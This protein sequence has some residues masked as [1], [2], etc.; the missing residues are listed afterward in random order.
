M[1]TRQRDSTTL[2]IAKP[3]VKEPYRGMLVI[4]INSNSA[5]AAEIFARVMQIEQRGYVVGDRSMGA[6]ITSRTYWREVGGF[7]R[8]LSYGSS[9]S[10]ADV[11]MSDGGRIENV[12]VMPNARVLLTG[13]DLA[14]KRDPQMA[15]ALEMVG[16]LVTPEEAGNL[17]RS[18]SGVKEQ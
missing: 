7:D 12:G 17:S 3:T 18:L 1:T 13:A 11:I 14:A 5:S 15:K 2:R 6:V 4:L 9:I 16:V 10:F 8:V